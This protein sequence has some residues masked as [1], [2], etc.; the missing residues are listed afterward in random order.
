[1]AADLLWLLFYY[2]YATVEI[3]NLVEEEKYRY[4]G[5]IWVK[6]KRGVYWLSVPKDME[7][8][9]YTTEYKIIPGCFFYYVN[10]GEKIRINFYDKYEI[11]TE[12]SDPIDVKNYIATYPRL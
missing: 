9:S 3:Y 6:K 5:S 4:M 2:L 12:I 1:M 7:L 8:R 11:I 10:Q